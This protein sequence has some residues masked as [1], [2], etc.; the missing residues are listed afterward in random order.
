MYFL[1]DRALAHYKNKT[2]RR[3]S[4]RSGRKEAR[5]GRAWLVVKHVLRDRDRR[6]AVWI[7]KNYIRQHLRENVCKMQRGQYFHIYRRNVSHSHGP[8]T[9]AIAISPSVLHFGTDLCKSPVIKK[10]A[11]F[12]DFFFL[13]HRYDCTEKICREKKKSN[14]Y[15]EQQ[16]NNNKTGE[17]KVIAYK[18]RFEP[19]THTARAS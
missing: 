16:R 4:A 11:I 8:C 9:E 2:T 5:T 14:G 17:K 13:S 18:Q 19:H 12:L 10:R 3:A 6:P 15:M 7:E 1:Y